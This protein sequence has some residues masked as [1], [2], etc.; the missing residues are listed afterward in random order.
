MSKKV[1]A[2]RVRLKKDGHFQTKLIQARSP[3]EA[4]SRSLGRVLSSSKVSTEELLQIGDY[5]KLGDQLMKEFQ[6]E[7]KGCT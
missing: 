2:Y 7:E 5:F 3:R 6:K 4:A 1:R